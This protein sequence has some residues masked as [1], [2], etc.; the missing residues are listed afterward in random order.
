M[1]I[2]IYEDQEMTEKE[3]NKRAIKKYRMAED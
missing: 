2:I 3:A 1:D